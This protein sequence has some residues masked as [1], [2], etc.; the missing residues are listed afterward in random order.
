MCGKTRKDQ[1]RNEM[2]KRYL[3]IIATKDEIR[4]RMVQSCYGKIVSTGYAD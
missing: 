4:E 3:R 2:I 1:I